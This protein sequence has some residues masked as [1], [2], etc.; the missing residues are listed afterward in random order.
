MQMED[1]RKPVIHTIKDPPPSEP[2]PSQEKHITPHIETTQWLDD[3]KT[4]ASISLLRSTIPQAALLSGTDYTPQIAKLSDDIAVNQY[5]LK[6]QRCK[7]INRKRNTRTMHHIRIPTPKGS[8]HQDIAYEHANTMHYTTWKDDATHMWTRHP[9]GQWSIPETKDHT[10][11]PS[12]ITPHIPS[13]G[14]ANGSHSV[15]NVATAQSCTTPVRIIPIQD[16]IGANQNVTHIKSIIHDYVDIEPYPIGG[17][18]AD[19]VA[20]ICTGKGYLPWLSKEGVLSMVPILYCKEVDGTIVSPTTIVIHYKS[21]YSGFVI[22]TDTDNGTGVLRLIHRDG[23]HHITY[24]MTMHNSLWFHEYTP[25]PTHAPTVNRMNDACLSNLWHGRLAHSGEDVVDEIHKHVIGIDKPLRRNPFHKCG[26]CL[27]AKMSKQPHKRTA[28]H[29]RRSTL[30]QVILA[31]Q[32][33]PLDDPANADD[34]PSAGVAGQHFHM[35]FG[36]VRG[37][38]YSVKRENAPTITSIDGYNSYLIIV[39]RVTRY[40]WLFLTASKAPPLTIVDKVLNKFKC[41]NPHRTVRTDQGGELGRSHEFQKVVVKND[42]V[43]ELTGAAASAQ[44]AHAESPNKYLANMMRCLLHAADLGSEYWSFALIHAAYIKNRIPH[45]YIRMTPYEAL[46]GA[47]PNITNLRTFG[48]RVFVRKP[49]LKKAKLDYNT[50]NGIFVGYTATTKN[51]YYI[52]DATSIVKIGTH[53]LF[54]EAHFTAPRDK[55]PLAAQ[56]LQSLGYSAF[57]DEFKNG[58]FKAKHA[59]R[60]TMIHKD[61]IAPTQLAT[62]S[63]GMKLHAIDKD[64]VIPPGTTTTLSTGLVLDIPSHNFWR[65]GHI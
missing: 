37:S 23:I 46:T 51:I 4:T 9:N 21:M 12:P 6:T 11:A 10:V 8:L 57:R 16:D 63:I 25:P 44:N 2:P 35:D 31:P 19:D 38:D 22:E 15:I 28:K 55:Q 20:I 56:A 62:N 65:T 36:F 61:A 27:P 7:H 39:D 24:P 18:K 26:S 43:L 29:K 3:V 41:K 40:L 1:K 5:Q 52:D 17:V 13:L 32:T 33:P 59:L 53:A 50:S 14:T 45:T 30:E 42:F 48:C 34:V 58:K 60:I 49:N 54:D 47:K 64:T